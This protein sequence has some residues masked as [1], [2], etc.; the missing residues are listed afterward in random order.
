MPP[1][2][3]VGDRTTDPAYGHRGG[4]HECAT[5]H[6]VDMGDFDLRIEPLEV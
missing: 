4:A 3:A 2:D 1:F 6:P 5:T